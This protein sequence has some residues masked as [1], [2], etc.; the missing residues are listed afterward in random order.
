MI[1]EVIAPFD[2][3]NDLRRCPAAAADSNG[4][5]KCTVGFFGMGGGDLPDDDFG[6]QTDDYASAVAQAQPADGLRGHRCGQQAGG[7]DAGSQSGSDHPP[8]LQPAHAAAQPSGLS[9]LTLRQAPQRSYSQP[10]PLR[11]PASS[12]HGPTP[13][14]AFESQEGPS[15]A[16]RSP[17]S[18]QSDPVTSRA[19]PR[20]APWKQKPIQL[21]SQAHYL[22]L[23]KQARGGQVAGSGGHG[24]VCD[25]GEHS[26]CQGD[27]YA[28]EARQR[29]CD[30]EALQR[31]EMGEREERGYAV[32][33][34]VQQR[35]MQAAPSRSSSCDV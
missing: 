13:R 31:K 24:R 5:V 28:R 11:G 29:A 4:A 7:P 26:S 9:P 25:A 15:G 18:A 3:D 35:A 10:P 34:R 1:T 30:V 19:A 16:L 20:Q 27:G 32:M 22:D 23:L 2:L 17:A 8:L 21:N 6:D 33:A 12:S 14:G